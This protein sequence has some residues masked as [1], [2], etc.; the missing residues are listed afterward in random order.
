MSGCASHPRAVQREQGY[1]SLQDEAVRVF[2][3]LQEMETLAD[4]VPIIQ[5]ILQT[6]QDLKPLRDEVRT[7]VHTHTHTR[8]VSL[9]HTH[10]HALSVSNT[11]TH[12]LSVSNAHTQILK[13]S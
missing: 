11:H 4:T 1:A 9:K 6:C 2:N 7:A 8:S 3:S 13:L 10:T 12:I 5:G